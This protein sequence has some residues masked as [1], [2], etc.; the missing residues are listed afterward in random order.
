MGGGN[1]SRTP[2]LASDSSGSVRDCTRSRVCVAV[3]VERD[4]RGAEALLAGFRA[5]SA[6]PSVKVGSYSM[7]PISLPASDGW[8]GGGVGKVGS[9]DGETNC[10]ACIHKRPS[11]G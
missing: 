6:F 11:I 4:E 7:P 9:A 8:A 10:M 2:T 1:A 5:L 3:G